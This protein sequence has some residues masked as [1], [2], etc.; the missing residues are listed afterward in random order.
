MYPLRFNILQ[1]AI[2]S[3]HTDIKYK[4]KPFITKNRIA[5]FLI[6]ACSG[7]IANYGLTKTFITV[8]YLIK[9]IQTALKES[10]SDSLNN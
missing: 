8:R 6:A 7:I 4:K 9:K 1:P 3:I 2:K 10:K 5:F